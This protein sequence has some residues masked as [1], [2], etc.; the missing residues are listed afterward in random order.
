MG[1]GELYAQHCRIDGGGGI[2]LFDV[3]DVTLDGPANDPTQPENWV[4]D[5]RTP[6]GRVGTFPRVRLPDFYEN[7]DGLWIERGVNSDRVSQAFIA[8]HPPRQTLYVVALRNPAIIEDNWDQRRH[9]LQFIHG[10]VNYSLRIT[11]P[12]LHAV[13]HAADPVAACISLAPPFNGFHY[14]LAASLFW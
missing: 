2:N 10:A 12:L 11:D 8:Q 4:I 13:E 6:W 5:E 14:K 7:P 3:L 1:E 9:R